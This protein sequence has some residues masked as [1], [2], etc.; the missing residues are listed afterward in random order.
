M[1]QLSEGHAPLAL[2]RGGFDE[3]GL[4]DPDSVDEHEP[5]LVGGVRGHDPQVVVA[6]R[7]HA[8][9]LHLLEE[10]AAADH[11]MNT[12]SSSGLTSVPV[13]IMSTVTAI[14]GL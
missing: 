2:E 3:L 10:V 7:A 6:D 13:A 8:P 11:R 14:R 9:A 1:Q 4:G 12:T 5:V